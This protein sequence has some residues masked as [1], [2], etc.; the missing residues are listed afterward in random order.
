MASYV[1]F[2]ALAVISALVGLLTV[3]TAT[4]TNLYIFGV[5]LV[6]FGVAFTVFMIKKRYDENEAH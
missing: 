6:I 4:D 5:G 2:T 1:I 3:A